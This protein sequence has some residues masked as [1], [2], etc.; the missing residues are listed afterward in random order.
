M[1]LPPEGTPTQPVAAGYMANA[2]LRMKH[3]NYDELRRM[4]DIVGQTVKVRAR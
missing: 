2:W 3:D 4:L 1:H